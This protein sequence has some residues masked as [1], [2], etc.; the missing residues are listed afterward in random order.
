MVKPVGEGMAKP[1]WLF[2]GAPIL[3]TV[4]FLEAYV[5]LNSF[6][7]LVQSDLYPFLDLLGP[8][9]FLGAMFLFIFYRP[10]TALV[11]AEIGWVYRLLTLTEDEEEAVELEAKL[12]REAMAEI[13]AD[14]EN[15]ESGEGASS[16]SGAEST[17]EE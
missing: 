16:V 6:A 10:F 11:Y 12:Y 9:M 4:L 3:A 2:R 5:F 14:A 13:A 17:E 7:Y 1:V 15:I 8:I